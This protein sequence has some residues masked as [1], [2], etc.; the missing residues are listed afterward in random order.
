MRISRG[1]MPDKGKLHRAPRAE[2]RA[3]AGWSWKYLGRKV[4]DKVREAMM[5]EGQWWWEA[6]RAFLRHWRDSGFTTWEKDSI[7]KFWAEERCDP[8]CIF[9]RSYKVEKLQK[10]IIQGSIRASY[11]QSYWPPLSDWEAFYTEKDRALVS[12][13]NMWPVWPTSEP[14]RDLVIQAGPEVSPLTCEHLG[15]RT[16]DSKLHKLPQAIVTRNK[17]NQMNIQGP[18]SSK[19]WEVHRQPKPYL[20]KEMAINE[21]LNWFILLQMKHL[22]F[23]FSKNLTQLFFFPA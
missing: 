10:E 1:S 22:F 7:C 5:G 8:T 15:L 11:L 6:H 23:P 4:R 2:A 16:G 3:L 21:H 9:K 20:S 13:S 17:L 19:L 18:S 12:V 14:P